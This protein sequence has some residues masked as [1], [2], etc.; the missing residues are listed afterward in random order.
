M[1]KYR[2]LVKSLTLKLDLMIKLDTKLYFFKSGVSLDNDI[3]YFEQIVYYR[4]L[5][6]VSNI[7][8]KGS[9]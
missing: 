7:L 3:L 2:K 1:Y 9:T 4:P 8:S 5:V 6:L